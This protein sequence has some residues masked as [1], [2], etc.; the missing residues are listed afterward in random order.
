MMRPKTARRVALWF[1][2]MMICLR[3]FLRFYKMEGRLAPPSCFDAL[4]KKE[5]NRMSPQGVTGLDEN[6]GRFR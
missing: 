5:Y 2:G 1:G 4:I 6:A 3:L